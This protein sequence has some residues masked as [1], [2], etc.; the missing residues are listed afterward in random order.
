M[1]ASIFTT[2]ARVR[3]AASA[4]AATAHLALG[5]GDVAWGSNPP[6]PSVNST[7]LVAE[8]CRRRSTLVQF[9]SP[10]QNGSIVV[11]DGK[12]QPSVSATNCVYFKFHF[13]FGDA[14]GNTIREM[15][16][17]LDTI[18]TSATPAGQYLLLPANVQTPGSLLTIQRRAPDLIEGTTRN[19]FEIVVTF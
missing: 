10:N 15:G 12:F 3:A 2:A 11:P 5:S 6:S 19:L 13:D 8:F 14:V 1:G 16:I 18:A 17:F 7:A 4:Q 9:C